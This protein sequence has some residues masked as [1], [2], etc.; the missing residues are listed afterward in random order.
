[1][2]FFLDAVVI[3]YGMWHFLLERRITDQMD[4]NEVAFV[5][6]VYVVLIGSEMCS[7][8]LF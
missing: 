8:L 6:Y 1:M 3:L 4:A 5:Q 7:V 2:F